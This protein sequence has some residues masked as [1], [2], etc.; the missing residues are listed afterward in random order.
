MR[1][2]LFYQD[3]KDD[4][5]VEF[6]GQIEVITTGEYRKQLMDMMDENHPPPEGKQFMVCNEKSEYF[7]EGKG[8]VCYEQSKENSL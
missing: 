8:D 1:Y 7:I 2:Q 4:Q 6:L 5:K 3:R